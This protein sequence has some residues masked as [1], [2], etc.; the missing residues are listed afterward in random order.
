[1]RIRERAIIALFILFFAEKIDNFAFLLIV[2]TLY[3]NEKGKQSKSINV[4]C[5]INLTG[6]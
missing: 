3:V 5:S 2:K 6:K 4:L 1:M